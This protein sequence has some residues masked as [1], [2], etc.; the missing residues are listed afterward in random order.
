M[1]RMGVL[2]F[3]VVIIDDILIYSKSPEE[4]ATDLREVLMK[5]IERSLF[6]NVKKTILPKRGQITRTHD[7]PVPRSAKDVQKTSH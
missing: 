4:H 3:V 6:I 1:S 5:L 7:H 2:K